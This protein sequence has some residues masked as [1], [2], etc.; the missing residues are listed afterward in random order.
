[1]RRN[2]RLL[3][4]AAVV[5]ASTALV[6]D[7]SAYTNNEETACCNAASGFAQGVVNSPWA[8]DSSFF[9]RRGT[10]PALAFVVDNYEGLLDLP[11][12]KE[13]LDAGSEC[14]N[15]LLD[16]KLV[17]FNVLGNYPPV[18]QGVAGTPD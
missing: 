7:A 15:P 10:T 3:S 14:S 18:D 8:G 12:G 1:M 16:S 6:G 17:A 5:L 2:L 4:L 9:V 11:F 13:G